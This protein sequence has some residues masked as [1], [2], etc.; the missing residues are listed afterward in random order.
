MHAEINLDILHTVVKLISGWVKRN[1]ENA[2][3]LTLC[4]LL[5]S[6]FFFF[7]KVMACLL[8][9]TLFYIDPLGKEISLRVICRC[10]QS[11][12]SRLSAQSTS[13]FVTAEGAQVLLITFMVAVLCYDPIRHEVIYP[14]LNSVIS[15]GAYFAFTYQNPVCE[16]GR[17]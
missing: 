5:G 1:N 17:C 3:L 12:F 13:W 7:F 2:L 8:R 6:F 11:D 16:E 14:S 10:C 9:E 15:S 4:G